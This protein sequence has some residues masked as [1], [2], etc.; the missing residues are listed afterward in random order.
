MVE[1]GILTSKDVSFLYDK[2]G[3][4]K[5]IDFE[6]QK[7][8]EFHEKVTDIII[9]KKLDSINEAIE[10]HAVDIDT[11]SKKDIL[12]QYTYNSHIFNL[13]I[14]MLYSGDVALFSKG[15]PDNVEGFIASSYDQYTKRLA[16]DIAP[17]IKPS[18]SKPTYTAI[19]LKA[20]NRYSK[21]YEKLFLNKYYGK[22]DNRLWS[23]KNSCN[24][25]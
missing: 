4:I 24:C 17:G 23:E 13:S 19:T 22:E 7:F 3:K 11:T 18:F 5:K 2:K 10:R 14:A 9:Q 8:Y 12:E 15:N 25:R 20:I 21:E 16:K 6:S 1:D